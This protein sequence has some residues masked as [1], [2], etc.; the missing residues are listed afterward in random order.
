M[1][2]LPAS[3]PRR[4]RATAVGQIYSPSH[5][6][7]LDALVLSGEEI[8]LAGAY[9]QLRRCSAR[10]ADVLALYSCICNH[11][12][13]PANPHRSAIIDLVK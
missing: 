6:Q 8:A 1:F 12:S 3:Y 5:L 7:P 10:V 11:P 13:H 4:N 9:A 2:I